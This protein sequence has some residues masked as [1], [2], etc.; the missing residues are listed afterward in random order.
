MKKPKLRITVDRNNRVHVYANKKHYKY[1]TK[2]E[3]AADI[4]GISCKATQHRWIPNI[5]LQVD[6]NYNIV[7]DEISIFEVRNVR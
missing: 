3:F 5:G 6:E 4:Y 1:L 2:L 7:A